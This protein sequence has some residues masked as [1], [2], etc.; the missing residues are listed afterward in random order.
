MECGINVE[1]GSITGTPPLKLSTINYH[2]LSPIYCIDEVLKNKHLLDMM[3]VP[4]TILQMAY[5]K[6]YIPL[7]LLM[8]SALLRLAVTGQVYLP[9]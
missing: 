7:S 5:L 8:T 2:S 6:L 9:G 4:N 1:P 3:K